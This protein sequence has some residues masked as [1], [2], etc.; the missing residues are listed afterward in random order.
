MLHRPANWWRL[1]NVRAPIAKQHHVSRLLVDYAETGA[2]VVRLKSG[3]SGLFGRLE[4]NKMRCMLRALSMK[5]FL[6]S[7]RP[8]RQRLRRASH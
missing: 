4:E 3:D 6:A 1:A 5:L 8:W 2:Q 7:P